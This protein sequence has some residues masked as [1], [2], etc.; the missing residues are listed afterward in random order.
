M[1]FGL[2]GVGRKRGELFMEG[3]S[4]LI[5]GFVGVAGSVLG[6]YFAHKW[7][8]DKER[9]QWNRQQEAENK[10]SLVEELKSGRARLL[11]IYN[12]AIHYLTAYMTQH[13]RPIDEEYD[14]AP[15]MTDEERKQHFLDVRTS[16][17]SYYLEAQKYVL[18]LSL[19]LRDVS[20]ADLKR[21]NELFDEF[22]DLSGDTGELRNLL[23]KFAR[24]DRRLREEITP[25]D[26]DRLSHLLLQ[27]PKVKEIE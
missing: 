12:N 26:L 2:I 17:E 6:A 5:T 15:A 13:Y 20:D 23:V 7:S 11:E 10:K 22:I 8:L 1:P 4:A 21:F 27:K 16:Q 14:D 3:L 18:L 25:I 24:N 9:E 19:N